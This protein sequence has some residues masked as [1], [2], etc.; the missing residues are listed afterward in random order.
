LARVL[1]MIAAAAV[2][3]MKY[4]RDTPAALLGKACMMSS[5]AIEKTQLIQCTMSQVAHRMS[6]R[7]RSARNYPRNSAAM[8]TEKLE[9]IN[10]VFAR[11][12]EGDIQGRIVIGFQ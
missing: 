8:E 6:M 2:P 9:N 7:W 4:R 5:H 11:M 12:R 3:L 1:M 10:E